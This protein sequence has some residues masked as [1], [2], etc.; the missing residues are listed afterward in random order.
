ML[1]LA[2]D[3]FTKPV[4]KK[5]DEIPGVIYPVFPWFNCQDR[6]HKEIST[7]GIH[8]A[9]IKSAYRVLCP[10]PCKQMDI[11]PA[12]RIKICV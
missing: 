2:G 1:S 3:R 9:G 7:P 8:G 11:E 12:H 5:Q 6:P 10:Y 4:E